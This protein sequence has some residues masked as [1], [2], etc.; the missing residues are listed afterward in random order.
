LKKRTKKLLD[1]G[2]APVEP[3][4]ANDQKFFASFFQKRRFFLPNDTGAALLLALWAML[5]MATLVAGIR[6]LGLRD[7]TLAQTRL[8]QAQLTACAD[9]M[10]NATILRLLDLGAPGHPPVDGTPTK[11][12]FAGCTGQVSVQDE[13]GKIDLN[14]APA[15]LLTALFASQNLDIDDAQS[16]ADKILDWREP[17]AGRRLNGAKA[18]DYRR[19]GIAYAPR[20]GRMQSVDELRLVMGMTPPV[21]DALAPA[22]TVVS[23]N[24]WPDQHVAPP[25]VLRALAGMDEARIE[26]LETAR[27]ARLTTA[28]DGTITDPAAPPALGRAFTIQARIEG[29]NATIQRHAIIR[30][31]GIPS[32]PLVIYAWQ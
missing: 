29:R 14:Q 18:D 24:A 17:G 31:T 16:L 7:A 3:S 26:S 6:V 27:Q 23:Q 1:L 22:L 30:L 4:G 25:I 11:A 28:P 15:A 20:G 5:A 21:F 8:D 9:A 13:S 32:A 12:T 2:A 19:A 10:I